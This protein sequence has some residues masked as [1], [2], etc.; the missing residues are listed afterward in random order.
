MQSRWADSDAEA[1]VARY[2]GAGVA[3]DLALRVYTTRLLGQDP[4]LVLHGGGNTSLKTRMTDLFGE[5]TEVLCVKGSGQDM[6]AIE[7]AGLPAVRL[8][9]LLKLRA[10]DALADDDMVRIKRAALID[11]TA[12]DPSVE[13]L[14]HAFMPHRFIDHTHA[15]AVLGLIDQPNGPELCAEVYD[16]RL[17]I[18]PYRMPG[19]GLAKVASEVFDASPKVEGLILLK[20]GIFTFGDSARES[21]ERMI[22][23]VTRA[24][25]RLTRGRKTVF[26]AA[27]LPRD[28]A[29]RADVMPILR[30]AVKSSD[31][32]VEGAWRRLIFDF[33]AGDAILD[34]VNGHDIARYANEGVITP[35][36]AI[37]TKNWPLIV[38]APEAGRLDA[39]KAAVHELAQTF[40]AHYRDYFARHDARAGDS[41][42]ILDPAPRVVVVPGLGLFGLGRSATDARIAAD[43]AVAWVDGVTGAELIGTFESIPDADLFDC[44]YWP[45]EQTKLGARKEL[46]LA[47]QIAAITGGGGAIGAATAKAFAA[48]G[49]EVALLD[50]NLAAATEHAKA[51]G[52][53]ALP[54]RC[55][56]T[57]VAS[58]HAAF[59]QIVTTFGG[60]DILVS[61]AGAAWQGRIGEVDEAVLRK[62][63][64]TQFLW[65][66]ARRAGGGEDYAGTGHRWLPA[67]QRL[68]AGGEPGAELRSLRVAQGGDAVPVAAICGG[69]RR[70]RHPLQRGERRPHPLRAADR[71]F[72]QV[73]LRRA[74]LEREG[75]H[76]RQ[77]A[78]PRSYRRRCGAGVP[79]S[80]PGAKDDGR[81]HHRGRREYRRG[82]AVSAS[83]AFRIGLGTRQAQMPR[84][85]YAHPRMTAGSRLR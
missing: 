47:G 9:P 37:R 51:I 19:F 45:L 36:H 69:L 50:L 44:E 24:E 17:G 33:R 85:R 64:R 38:P 41:R 65:A 25:Q 7:P 46:P 61:N 42:H 54:V 52:G 15:T 62:I 10:R 26:P 34:F 23:M 83:S 82:I 6:G 73:A 20:H 8:A 12:P 81:C 31:E 68:Q 60:V 40:M 13:L 43:I 32:R 4:K 18:V 35:D 57:D 49:A 27:A 53:A 74:R 84:L 55:D 67:V 21:Y 3:R 48:A 11:P 80:G 30:G 59:E 72:H 16:D 70:R 71:R 14:L 58:V 76:E 75:L 39:F 63:L 2:A 29:P 79:G 1:T 56:V 22:E 66:P 5:E 28:V 77:P 78:W